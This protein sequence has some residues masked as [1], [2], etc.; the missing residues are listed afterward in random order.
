MTRSAK[1]C[2]RCSGCN[3]VASVTI[4]S[5]SL[6]R[7]VSSS[8]HWRQTGWRWGVYDL[9]GLWTGADYLIW[10]HAAELEPLQA[11]YADLRR[12]TALGWASVPV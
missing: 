4:A 8:R 9:T 7:P 1:P 5:G 3:L 6:S 10:W 12:D 11:A 2:G